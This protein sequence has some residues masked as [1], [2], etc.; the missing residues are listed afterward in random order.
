MSDQHIRIDRDGAIATIVL[1]RAERRNA[2]TPPM[3]LSLRTI[4]EGLRD[5]PE[6]RAVVIRG[7]GAHFSVG[8]DISQMGDRPP[9]TALIR[10]GAEAGAQLMRAIREISQP[11]ICAVQGIATGG[12]TCI[13]TACDFRIGA[14]GAR[15]GYGEVKLGI[16]LMW[17]ALPLAIQTVGL[18]RAKTMVMTGDLFEASTMKEWGFFDQVVEESELLGEAWKLAEQYASLP[19]VAVQMI[20]RSANAYAGALDQAIMHADADQW[21]LATRTADFKEGVASFFEKRPPRFTGD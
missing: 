17:H 6:I 19:P 20:K 4:A 18:S 8:A 7:E 9:Q 5:E 16:N 2:L 10:R 14:A 11:T 21:L 1:D 12:A 3:L 15:I 13:A